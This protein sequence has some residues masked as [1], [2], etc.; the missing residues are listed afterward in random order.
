MGW[1]VNDIALSN[2]DATKSLIALRDIAEA[3]S[4]Q[5]AAAAAAKREADN[6]AKLADDRAKLRAYRD[7]LQAQSPP[8]AS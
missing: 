7:E 5:A 4:R 2:A 8:R 6:E 3:P 1:P